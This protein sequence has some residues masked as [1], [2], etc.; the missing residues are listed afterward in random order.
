[1]ASTS[2]HEEHAEQGSRDPGWRRSLPI[3]W[4]AALAALVT[5][6]VLAAGCGGSK[7]PGA[8]GDGGSSTVL[9]KFDAYARCMRGHGVPDFPDPSTSPGGGVSFQ[10]DGGP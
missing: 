6:A 7:P 10:I 9:A 4:T 2:D 3:N 5:L 8:A 1:M